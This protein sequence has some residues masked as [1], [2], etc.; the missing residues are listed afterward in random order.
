MKGDEK[1]EHSLG[2]MEEQA[3]EGV[4]CWIG[5]RK[6]ALRITRL[7]V[8]GKEWLLTDHFS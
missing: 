1:E 4:I 8:M 2:W 6:I 3:M 7:V 5:S